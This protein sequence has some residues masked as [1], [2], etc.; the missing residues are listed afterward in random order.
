MKFPFPKDFL[1][2]AACSACQIE[3]GCNEGGKGEDVCEH[4]FKIYP[5]KFADGDPAKSADFYHRYPQD[6]A[7][8]KELGLKSFRFSFSWSR[9]F[10]NG[11]E[12]VNQA[13]IDYYKD[14]I[15]HLQA[16]GIIPFFD[17]W[18]CDLPYWVIERGGVLNPEFIEWFRIYARTMFRAIGDD[19][20]F[21]CTIN[22]PSVNIKASYAHGANAPFHHNMDEA[23]KAC[24]NGILAHYAAIREYRKLGLTGKIGMVVDM[25]PFYAWSLDPR[26]AA[27]AERAQ[28]EYSGWFL[29]PIVKGHYPDVLKDWDYIMGMLPEGYQKDLDENFTPV[30][31]IAI[32]YYSPGHARYKEDDALN[33]ETVRHPSLGQDDYGFTIYPS[34]M[35]DMLMYLKQTY[36]DKEVIITENGYGKKK[37]GDFEQE[38]EDDYR[39]DCIREHLRNLS[40]AYRAGV[41]VKGYFHWSIMDTS[42]LYTGGYGY[43]FG[44]TQINYETLERFPRKSWY[45]YQQVIRQG[46]VE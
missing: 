22:E 21:W 37:W 2:G 29:D 9:I 20:R 7:M 35:F 30:D 1:F 46:G 42:E 11:P 32:N 43:I 25:L 18:H 12:E 26:D 17:L 28:A 14:I 36:P 13:G 34:G 4:Y 15:K 38:R 27:A 3:A 31:Y 19:V 44:L 45:Y 23:I 16:A 39:V 41:N 40:R 10:P 24:H 33:Y 8:M 5:E 6:I